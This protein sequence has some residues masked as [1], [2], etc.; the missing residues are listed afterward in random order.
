MSTATAE[1][2]ATP[3][4]VP[5]QRA[6]LWPRNLKI[7]FIGV[8]VP[9]GDTDG[10]DVERML[11]EDPAAVHRYVQSDVEV[12]RALHRKWSGVFCI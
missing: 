7:P 3:S 9:A 4:A 10:S 2:T 1:P 5:T 8:P 12:T 6:P 11:A